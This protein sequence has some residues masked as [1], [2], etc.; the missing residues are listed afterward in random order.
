V[1]ELATRFKCKST[2]RRNRLL[3]IINNIASDKIGGESDD[4]IA[5][6]RVAVIRHNK[7][8]IIYR[9]SSDL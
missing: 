5:V 3:R 9:A 8:W 7:S 2:Q 1:L 4:Q 6:K